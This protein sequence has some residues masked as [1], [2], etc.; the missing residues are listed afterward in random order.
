MAR[1]TV[2]PAII[3]GAADVWN[4]TLGQ[5]VVVLSDGGGVEVFGVDSTAG[6]CGREASGCALATIGIDGVSRECVIYLGMRGYS[7]ENRIAILAHEIGHCL[8]LGHDPELDSLMHADVHL[9]QEVQPWHR[10]HVLG[11]VQD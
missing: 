10:D 1:S 6:V 9:G 5:D 11:C 7:S 2:D 8:G 3:L 4:E